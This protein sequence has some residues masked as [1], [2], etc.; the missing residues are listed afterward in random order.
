[1]RLAR[2]AAY[3]LLLRAFP[4]EFRR[5][6]GRE[7]FDSVARARAELGGGRLAAARFWL[8]VAADVLA[9]AVRLR[10]RPARTAQASRDDRDR[11]RVL[12]GQ[13]LGAVMGSLAVDLHHARRALVRTPGVAALIVLTLGLGIGLNTAV[14]SVVHGVLLRP[15][16]YAEPPW[17]TRVS[18]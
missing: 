14:F 8:G 6:H 5:R 1:M 7:L 2:R 12:R 11:V 17:C 18:S 10:V 13:D 9:A 16:A 15:F 4:R 3:A